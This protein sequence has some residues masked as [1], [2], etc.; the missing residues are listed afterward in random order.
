VDA[1]IRWLRGHA[2]EYGID[3]TRVAVWGGSAGGQLAGL[4][5]TDCSPGDGKVESDCVQAAAIW[6]GVFDMATIGGPPPAAAPPPPGRP[7]GGPA[8]YLGCQPAACVDVAARASPVTFVD[9]KDPPFLLIHGTA[10]RTVPFG[11]STEMLARLKGAGVPVQLIDLPGF[12]HSFIGKTP[13]ETRAGHL[14]ALQATFDFFDATV[15]KK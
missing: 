15:G 4:A 11:Q 14:K 12:D 7:A 8:A 10:D 2:A 1:A 9:A 3:K 6:Y 5:A 13:Q